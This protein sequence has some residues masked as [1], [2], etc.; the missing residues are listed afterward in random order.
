VNAFAIPLLLLAVGDEPVKPK[1]PLGKDTTVVN[2]PLDKNGYIDYEAA[3]NERLGKGIKPEQNANV[4]LWQVFGP[5]PG[6]TKVPA[7]YFK[8]LGAPEP[9]A[10]GDYFVPFE[11]FLKQRNIELSADESFAQAKRASVGPWV[12][13]DLPHVAAWLKANEKPLAVVIEAVKRPAYFNPLVAPRKDGEREYLIGALLPSASACREVG[14]ALGARAMKCA[15]EGDFD[16]SWRDLRTAFLLSRYVARGA[17]LLEALTGYAIHN[18]ACLA[19]VALIHQTEPSAVLVSDLRRLPELFGVGEKMNLA[20]RF[21]FLD[22]L[23]HA[24]RQG[25]KGLPGA[26]DREAAARLDWSIPL[27]RSNAWYDRAAT[28]ANH[29]TRAERQLAFDTFESN[30]KEL[31]V[32]L[33]QLPSATDAPDVVAARRVGDTLVTTLFPAVQKCQHARDRADQLE[34]NLHVAVALA[35]YRKANGRYPAKLADLAPKF[36]PEVPSDLFAERPL[37]YKPDAN[38]YLLYSVGLNGKDDG[39][40]GDDLAVRVPLPKP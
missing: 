31:R 17:T 10:K 4:L 16:A 37:N 29:Q 9:P 15:G 26:A 6:G 28:A 18:E 30:L 39:G 19:T 36:L 8:W 14:F 24:H 1:L 23:Q 22:S 20:E 3:L 12:E 11:Q 7:E 35:A 34:R 5:R 40:T 33:V 2:G 21:V 27:R 13:R 25:I 38:G 32:Q